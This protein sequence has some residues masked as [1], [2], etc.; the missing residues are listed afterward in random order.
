MPDIFVSPEKE[1]QNQTQAKSMTA[2]V[3]PEK[4]PTTE[5]QKSALPGHTHR[6]FSAFCLYPDDIDFETKE[7]DEKIV[8]ML[9]AHIITNIPWVLATIV[10]IFIPNVLRMLGVFSIM[11]TG[12]ELIITLAWYLVTSAYALEKFLSWYFNVYFI[13]NRR[14]IDVDFYNL[15]DKKVSE[16]SIDKIQDTNY[17][18]FGITRMFFDYGD[19]FIQTAAEVSEFDFLSVPDPDRVTKILN[20][21]KEKGGRV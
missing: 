7:S 13:T 1:G 20:E 10:L 11:P 12:F 17:T 21:L 16:A 3:L 19:V 14:V 4:D 15:I 9:R 2:D 5:A 18:N 8:L 6:P